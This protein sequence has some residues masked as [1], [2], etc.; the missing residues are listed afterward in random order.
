MKTFLKHLSLV[1]VGVFIS[2]AIHLVPSGIQA[3][4]ASLSTTRVVPFENPYDKLNDFPVS[5]KPITTPVDF[6]IPQISFDRP[7]NNKPLQG[8]INGDGLIDIYFST[9]DPGANSGVFQYVYLNN[10]HG[11][12]FVYLCERKVVRTTTYPQVIYSTQYRGDCADYS[13]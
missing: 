1:T 11:Y 10:G 13:N 7:E 5:D 12:D 3:V 4:T 8:D 2:T 9:G 6:A